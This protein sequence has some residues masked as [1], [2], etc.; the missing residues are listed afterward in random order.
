MLNQSKFTKKNIEGV[1][2]LELN[3]VFLGLLNQKISES[4]RTRA[5]NGHFH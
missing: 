1:H 5:Y 2:K 3:I 4:N